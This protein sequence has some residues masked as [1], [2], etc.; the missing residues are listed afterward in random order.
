MLAGT[1]ATS[2]TSRSRKRVLVLLTT[3]ASEAAEYLA[4]LAIHGRRPSAVSGPASA[5]DGI[6]EGYPARS[7]MADRGP[8][9]G[10]DGS[11]KQPDDGGRMSDDQDQPHRAGDA[12]TER[13]L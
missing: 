3:P 1:G 4:S 9:M 10:Q 6:R 13:A 7:R 5:R 12:G 2:K 11:R 8:V